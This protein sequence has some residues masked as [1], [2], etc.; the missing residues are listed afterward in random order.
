ML[1]YG[2]EW[3]SCLVLDNILGTKKEWMKNKWMTLV[4]FSSNK[5]N[6]IGD[7][8]PILY[9]YIYI[10]IYITPVHV[11][12]LAT[13]EKVVFVFEFGVDFAGIFYDVFLCT[14]FCII[15]CFVLPA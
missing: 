3:Q 7:I 5:T 13:E 9:I 15:F 12:T 11:S 1:K 4:H 2:S 10:Y 8:F 6:T 14:S